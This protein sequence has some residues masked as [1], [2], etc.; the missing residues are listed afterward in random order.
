MLLATRHAQPA[1]KTFLTVD[2]QD[3]TFG[4]GAIRAAN[5]AQSAEIAQLHIHIG[6]LGALGSAALRHPTNGEA[7]D[8]IHRFVAVLIEKSVE[9]PG[10]FSVDRGTAKNSFRANLHG[11]SARHQ[12]IA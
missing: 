10:N 1:D 4:D 6:R 5:Y 9:F 12:R 3:F 2:N 11:G 7:L 8:L